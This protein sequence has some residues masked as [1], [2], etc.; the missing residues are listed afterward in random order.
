MSNLILKR[1][2]ELQAGDTILAA[3]YCSGLMRAVTVLKVDVR[4]DGE[5]A[6][7]DVEAAQGTCPRHRRKCHVVEPDEVVAVIG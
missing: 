3:H 7:I 5:L 1:A 2:R 6:V 4:S